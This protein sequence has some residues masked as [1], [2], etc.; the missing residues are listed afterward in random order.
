MNYQGKRHSDH[1]MAPSA[2]LTD[3]SDRGMGTVEHGSTVTGS[4]VTGAYKEHG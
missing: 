1:L 3:R 4:T 2:S